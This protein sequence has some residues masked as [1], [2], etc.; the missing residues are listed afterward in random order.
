MINDYGERI[1]N[2]RQEGEWA[3]K[4]TAVAAVKAVEEEE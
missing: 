1:R 3:I 2:R 4:V